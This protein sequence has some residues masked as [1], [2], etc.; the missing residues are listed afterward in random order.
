MKKIFLL[1][2]AL[3]FVQISIQAQAPQ[4]INYQGVARNQQG[5]AYSNKNLNVRF[6]ILQGSTPVYTETHAALTDT[7]GLYNEVIGQG[8]TSDNFSTINWGTGT[9]SVKVEIDDLLGGGYQTVST[10]SLMSVPYALYAATSG[11]SSNGTVTS[12]TT[13]AGLTSTPNPITTTGT[14]DLPTLITPNT[15][16]DSISYPVIT[17]DAYGRITSASTQ[18]ISSGNVIATG[19]TM[20]STVNGNTVT[21]DAVNGSAIWNANQIQ[22]MPV[23]GGTPGTGQVLQFNGTQWAPTNP[24]AGTF[25]SLS[26]G[27]GLVPT[28]TYTNT[29]N[30]SA[31]TASAIWNAKKIQSAPVSITFPLTGDILQFNGGQWT[32]SPLPPGLPTGSAGAILYNP[33]GGG[34]QGTNPSNIFTDGTNI[35]IGNNSPLSSLDIRTGNI[36]GGVKSEQSGTG[37]AAGMFTVMNPANDSAA[38]IVYNR[39]KGAGVFGASDGIGHGGVFANINPASAGSG[40]VASSYG[41][42]KAVF[43]I[44]LGMGYAGAFMVNN[45]A[46]DSDA[47]VGLTNGDGAGVHGMNAGNGPGGVFEVWT[48]AN[49]SPA[50]RAVTSGIG[51]S[52]QFS[53][54]AGLQTDKIQIT[55]TPAA[56]YVLTS[57]AL[58]NGSW[59]APSGAGVSSIG[60]SPPLSATGGSTPVISMTQAGSTSDGW[61]AM[62][63]WNIFFNK[64]PSVTTIGTPFTGNGTS[65]S[66]L[67]MTMATGAVDG[68]LSKTDWNN[69]NNKLT[70][71]A[72]TAPLT[73]N[74]TGVSPVSIPM[75]TG[76]VDGYLSK[77]DWNLF[78]GKGTVNSVTAGA[79]LTGGTIVNTGTISLGTTG[80]ASGTYGSST[81]IPQITVDAFGRLTNVTNTSFTAGTVT[82]L[83]ASAGELTGGTITTTGTLGLANTGVTPGTYGS[84]SS[85]PTFTVDAKGRITNITTTA[86]TTSGTLS[87]GTANYLPKWLTPTS[88]SGTSLLYDDGTKVGVNNAAPTTILDVTATAVATSAAF[89]AA[90]ANT[91]HPAGTFTITSGTNGQAALVAGTSG[92]GPAIYSQGPLRLGNSLL[93][94]STLPGT[95]GQLLVSQG[96]GLAPIWTNPASAIASS[97]A[98]ING[99]NTLTGAGTIGSNTAHDVSIETGGINRIVVKSTGEVG[100]NTTPTAQLDINSNNANGALT[101]NHN[102]NTGAAITANLNSASANGAALYATSTST[103]G[104]SKVIYANNTGGG[105]AGF[106]A[107]GNATSS[108]NAVYA[109]TNGTGAAISANTSGA[110]PAVQGITTGSGNSGYFQVNNTGNSNI[111][112]FAETNGTGQAIMGQ[113]SGSSGNAGYF[114]NNNGTNISPA[115]Y[116][117]TSNASS[118]SGKFSG[119]A[120]V[121]TDKL[122]VS[123]GAM[124]K[125]VLISTNGAGD[126]IWE[127]PA[128][129]SGFGSTT[130]IPSGT[131]TPITFQTIDYLVPAGSFNSTMFTAPIGGL[132]HFDAGVTINIGGATGSVSDFQLQIMKNGGT[133]RVAYQK[134]PVGTVGQVHSNLS[135]DIMLNTGETVQVGVYQTAGAGV[136]AFTGANNTWFTGHIVH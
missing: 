49:S 127:G 9:Y 113:Q 44:N 83:T 59:Q 121:S 97:G 98:W 86:V 48:P 96:G 110:S 43:G 38:L 19:T 30:I 119:G 67:G 124:N 117:T 14:I 120:G 51:Y 60:A 6:T 17:V 89:K 46:N 33:T 34:W 63:D 94:A 112:L 84:A 21:V 68:Y 50:L 88:L 85:I 3:F 91:T 61:L 99:G 107:I 109:T 108:G 10:S 27:A 73:G 45:T 106:F 16:G 35:G 131:L 128:N 79:G 32:P 102:N 15:F 8:T 125:G 65:G 77:T 105:D 2:S 90:Q 4:G 39:G 80:V 118:F 111:A 7:F 132:Y 37:G 40:L 74:G 41:T 76:T 71:V 5:A 58:G 81:Q 36:N 129:F 62:A 136:N 13:G 95:S 115:L 103:V 123:A 56:G 28:G 78:N 133:Y 18:T 116:V 26:V 64:L 72:V 101:V 104:T 82:S 20:I 75:A 126:A 135:V 70:T 23:V 130:N 57:D 66:P 31:D 54:G 87:G 12:I 22:N 55:N 122:Q 93:D 53:G 134:L 52:G 11:N 25:T 69:F 47:V 100:I 29:A 42:G 24:N 92:S 1:L 114:T